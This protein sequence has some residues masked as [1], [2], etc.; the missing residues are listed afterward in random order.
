MHV[1]DILRETVKKQKAVVR[2][3]FLFTLGSSQDTPFGY[4]TQ[5]MSQIFME[6]I[7]FCKVHSYPQLL[8]KLQK[9][10]KKLYKNEA[11]I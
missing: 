10:H 3:V 2:Q 5:D 8:Y 7:F 4:V 6:I 1:M 11:L 9:T